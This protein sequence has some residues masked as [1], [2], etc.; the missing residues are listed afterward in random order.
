MENLWGRLLAWPEYFRLVWKGLLGTN[1]LA[2]AASSAE[3]KSLIKLAQSCKFYWF[4]KNIFI[5]K[6]PL[7]N[8]S[9]GTNGSGVI[10]TLELVLKKASVPPLCW[11]SQTFWAISLSTSPATG[12]G[13]EPP[14][15]GMQASIPP[16]CTHLNTFQQSLSQSQ[17][18]FHESNHWPYDDKIS[19]LPLCNSPQNLWAICL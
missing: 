17:Y 6:K 8:L 9:G 16:L 10:W 1:A 2:Y 15:H 3:T 11:S 19:V 4:G 13:F 5:L 14:T 7:C 18:Q 12:D